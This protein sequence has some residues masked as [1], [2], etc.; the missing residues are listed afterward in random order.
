MVDEG[1]GEE[2]FGEC[3]Y[4]AEPCKEH[5]PLSAYYDFDMF[6]AY[7]SGLADGE[8]WVQGFG[9]LQ[10]WV[11]FVRSEIDKIRPNLSA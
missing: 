7:S 2:Y 6:L 3:G 5:E 9:G 1:D 10:E 8:N 4:T 11:K